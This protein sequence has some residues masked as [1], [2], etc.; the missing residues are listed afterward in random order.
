MPESL[1]RKLLNRM[2]WDSKENISDYE[3]TFLHRGI[4]P[5]NLKTYPADLIK[6]IKISYLL[7]MTEDQEEIVIPF[8]RIRRIYNK[9]TNQ[10][11]WEKQIE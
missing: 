4:E 1:I 8:H 10:I 3:I 7:F 11:I 6:E 9:K 5:S 2:K